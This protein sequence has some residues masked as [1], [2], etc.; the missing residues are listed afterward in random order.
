MET[1]HFRDLTRIY[2]LIGGAFCITF[3]AEW[4]LVGFLASGPAGA[5]I[6]GAG[7]FAFLVIGV[8]IIY[9]ALERYDSMLSPPPRYV[10]YYPVQYY[11]YPQ[12]GYPPAGYAYYQP[13]WYYPPQGQGANYPWGPYYQPRTAYYPAPQQYLP[14]PQPQPPAE[15]ADDAGNRKPLQL[16]SASLLLKVFLAALAVGG[17]SL[18]LGPAVGYAYIVFPIAF[19]IGFSFPSL[20]WISYVYGFEKREPR[21]SK[22]ILLAFTYGMVSTMPALVFNTGVAILVG[23]DAEKATV[24]ASLLAA[25]VGAPLIEEF[26]KPWGVLVVGQHVRSR[27]DGLIFG[28]TCGVG[29]ALIENIS[30][31]LSFALTGQNPAAVWTFGAL[32]RGLGSIMIHATGAGLIGYAY[33]RY[34]VKKGSSIWAIP[35]AYA[36]AVIMHA[37]WNGASVLLPELHLWDYLDIA[38]I[39]LFAAGA[40][41]LLRHFIERGAASE[42]EP[43]GY[44]PENAINI[45]G[46]K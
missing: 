12:Q 38:F 20:I 34:R 29:F 40:F 35:L 39:P 13:G 25:A 41:L 17:L 30:Y 8:L 7:L 46:Q 18:A 3:F 26:V 14:P 23:A 44:I 19:I 22:S 1:I 33:G 32:A 5:A 36:A 21:P 9:I 27:L 11:Y 10:P 31:E 15:S 4:V 28:V 24:M 2:M 42:L 16:P 37:A 45:Y 43:G 6:C